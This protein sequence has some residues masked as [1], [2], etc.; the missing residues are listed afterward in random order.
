MKIIEEFAS[1]NMKKIVMRNNFD[2]F[3]NKQNENP[4]LILDTLESKSIRTNFLKSKS[5]I[6]FYNLFR[7]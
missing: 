2:F 5:Y 4:Y 7:K 1:S 3:S 6:T